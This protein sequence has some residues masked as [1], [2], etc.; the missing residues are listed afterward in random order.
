MSKVA[1][2]PSMPTSVEEKFQL[3]F[4]RNEGER[5]SNSIGIWDLAPWQVL[6][7]PSESRHGGKFLDSISRQFEARG[8][9]YTLTLRPARVR[10]QDGIETDQYPGEREQLVEMAMRKIAVQQQGLAIEREMV[11]VSI[12][13][14]ELFAEL[15]DTGHKMRYW[16]IEEALAVLHGAQVEIK[17]VA[18]DQDGSP[19]ETVVSST[20]FPTLAL[21]MNRRHEDRSEVYVQ[22][23]S[24][25]TDAIRSLDFH[26]I[27]YSVLMALKPVPRWIYK[28]LLHEVMF[29]ASEDRHTLVL[30]ASAIHE[31]CGMGSYARPRDAFDRITGFITEL[32]DQGGIIASFVVE[33]EESGEGRG[34]RLTDMI[35]R[36]RV[37]DAFHNGAEAAMRGRLRRIEDFRA[38]TKREPAD[39]WVVSTPTL[40]AGLRKRTARRQ[41][42]LSLL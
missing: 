16:Q 38:L 26:E 31:S 40:R 11:S 33:R 14:Y 21:R 3:P 35:Y 4:L 8:H 10:G 23:N 20:I 17:R 28:R 37:T 7:T 18:A 5:S 22:F 36:I 27:N 19:I 25:I 15:R 1:R 30:R 41:D 34:R 6:Y 9:T 32:R 42:Q 2:M 12:G 29:G 13:I 24:L 39:G